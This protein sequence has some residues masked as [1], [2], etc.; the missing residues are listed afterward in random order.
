VTGEKLMRI[1]VGVT[2]EKLK[3]MGYFIKSSEEKSH[4]DCGWGDTLRYNIYRDTKQDT[5]YTRP[6]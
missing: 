4:E 1:L 5:H 6:I 2:G 3:R